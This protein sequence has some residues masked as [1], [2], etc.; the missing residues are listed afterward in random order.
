MTETQPIRSALPVSTED[1]RVESER[2]AARS[3]GANRWKA[4]VARWQTP[5]PL[6]ASWQILNSVGAYLAVWGLIYL[7]LAVSW[8]LVIPLAILAGGLLVRVF[9]I[10][11]DCGHGSFLASRSANAFWGS[12]T[13]LLTM[14]PY[15]HWRGEHAIHHGT[16][17]DLDRRGIGDIWTMTVNEYIAST[18]WKRLGYRLVRNPFVLFVLAPLVLL[19]V[20]QRFARRGADRRERLSVYGMNLAIV[21]MIAGMV[22]IFGWLPYLIIQLTIMLVA[23]SAGLWLFYLQ[24]QFEDA[25]WERGDDWDYAAAALRGSSFFKLPRVLQWFSGNIGF[26]HIH[27]LSPR[28]PNY[29]LEACHRSDPMFQEVK[30]MTM[31]ASLRTLG[32]RLWDESSKKLVGWR[33]LRDLKRA[34]RGA[35]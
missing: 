31:L 23:G 27:H 33:H 24:H 18:R 3:K 15:H 29:H 1:V 21:V 13:G 28:I 2:A 12:I 30:P 10:F 35:A 22:S 4:I 32:L 11:H 26:H 34:K 9:I 19:L 14:T 25:Y 17:G 7:S 20:I 5:S 6:R 16:T 8:W